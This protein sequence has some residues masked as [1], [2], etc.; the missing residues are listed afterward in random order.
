M[1]LKYYKYIQNG[2]RK[3][4]AAADALM[5]LETTRW[6]YYALPV[7]TLR[8]TKRKNVNKYGKEDK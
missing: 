3:L 5:W 8:K 2:R 1:I 6:P 4:N 7:C